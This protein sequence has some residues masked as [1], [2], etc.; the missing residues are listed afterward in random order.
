MPNRTQQPLIYGAALGIATY[1]FRIFSR[2][3]A[4]SAFALPD[5]RCHPLNGWTS[6][7]TAPSVSAL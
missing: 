1:A 6:S 4:P 7:A 5:R 2:I 3:R